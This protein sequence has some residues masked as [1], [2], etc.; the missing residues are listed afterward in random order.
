VSIGARQPVDKQVELGE[1]LTLI[2][3]TP[4][5]TFQEAER[6]ALITRLLGD[7]GLQPHTDEIGNVIAQVPGGEGP[8]VMLAAHLDT[9]F[10]LDTDVT[11]RKEGNKWSAPGIGD[12]SASLAVLLT[13]LKDRGEYA[14]RLPRI[15]FVATVGEEG[16]GDLRG[17]RHLFARE[18]P[19]DYFIAVD[20]HLGSVVDAAVGSKR[21]EFRLGAT[22][23]H[24]WGDFPSPSAVHGAA[25]AVASL[26]DLNPPRT[27]RSTFN[28]GQVWGGTGVNAIA[29]SAGFN[30]DLR[31]EDP[32]TLDSLEREALER[33][34]RSASRF[35]CELEIVKLGDRP[36][37]APVNRTLSR[38]ALATLAEK[39]VNA[40]ARASSTDANI[41]LSLDVPAI[42]FGVYHGWDAH[43]LSEGLYLDSLPLGLELLV[44]LLG[45]VRVLEE[46]AG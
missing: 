7:M 2:T 4:A 9:V 14:G 3:E 37:A 6:G 39:G 41:P 36:A 26:L 13:L 25:A 10:P 43:R 23:G 15:T 46:P 21:F 1:L 33:V 45:R 35:G 5:P 20:G 11:V 27:P 34:R 30:L 8:R 28:V 16:A 31:S 29:Q 38:L 42:S 19:C 12:N 40:T 18:V 24:S 44:N 22:G 17:V 32:K